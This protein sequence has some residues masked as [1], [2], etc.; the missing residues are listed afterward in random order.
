MPK[1]PP[2]AGRLRWILTITCVLFTAG[3]VVFATETGTATRRA[4]DELWRLGVRQVS[5]GEFSAAKKTIT[6][7]P[8]GLPLVDRVRTWL[9]EYEADHQERRR[10]DREDFDKYLRYAKE[11]IERKEYNHALSW[12][13]AAADLAEDRDV[14]L[15]TE[16]VRDLTSEALTAA[17]EHRQKAEWRK[18]YDSYW[19]LAE[20]FDREPRYKKL[21]RSALTH[22]RLDLMFEEGST[23]EERIERVR[24]EDAEYALECIGFYYV[25]PA[26][27][28]KITESGLEQMLL[29]AASKSAREH[30][31]GLKNEDDR[32]DFI[33]RVQRKLDQVRNAPSVDWKD[34]VRHFRRVVRDINRQTIRLKEEL[35]VSEIMRGALE[36]LDEFTTVIW[37][38]DSDEFVKHTRG[39]FIG[40]GI[41]IVKNRLTDEI[42]VV[43]PL[44][45]TPAYR[46]GIIAGDIITKVDGKAIKGISISKCVDVI[47]GPRNT[48]VTLTIRRGEKELD[49]TL[50]RTKVKIQSVK[51]KSRDESE[52]WNHWIDK[53][54]RIAYIRLTSFQRNSK[55]DLENT[56][57]KLAA[58]G[59]RGLVL[60]L[61]GNPGGLLDSA[62]RVS[63][64]FLKRGENVVSTRGR[65]TNENQRFDVSRDGA[66]ADL[67]MVVLTDERSASASEI[68]AG[69]IKDNHHG[70]VV[71]ARTFGK[72]S[73]QNL[74][75]LSRSR[76]KLKL[77]TARYY[78][79]SGVSLHRDPGSQEWGVEADIPIRLVQKEKF[80][81]WK[82]R[83]E[84]DRLGPPKP[85]V[86]EDEKKDD[87][88]EKGDADASESD[89]DDEAKKDEA[90]ESDGETE[91]ADKDDEEEKLPPL[92][93]PDENTRPMKDPQ[94]E[95]ALLL[96]RVQLLA[97]E[98]PTLA[99]ASVLVRD[100]ETAQP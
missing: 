60:D 40:V 61:R 93:Q 51:G 49:I 19:R 91:L 17:E 83:R 69:A 96:M 75:P 87:D 48:K 39:E 73:V 77:T 9:D 54:Q 45:D 82:M 72:F 81:L 66:H 7:I 92:E 42:E 43:T 57:E 33:A 63:S 68:L 13:L 2:R 20:L 97:S 27:F 86:K 23:W 90:G 12:A 71:G 35:I 6:E 15:K 85:E 70:T 44:E 46:A 99:S 62:W 18:A 50:T 26:D 3:G 24:W 55:E 88:E 11:R 84:A 80:N 59:L 31:D 25:E 47:T 21:E 29:L 16:W 1:H 79:P 76:A 52:R 56:L 38:Q 34:A 14:F 100:K 64:L 30:F 41:S 98:Y 10:L 74:I 94:L 67:P 28:K 22:L 78:L 5:R 8:H 89:K 58:E 65:H 53:E 32:N 95:A 36:P 4:P 37:P